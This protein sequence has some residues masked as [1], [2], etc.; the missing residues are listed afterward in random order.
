MVARKA[1]SRYDTIAGSR[2][3]DVVKQALLSIEKPITTFRDFEG[4]ARERLFKDLIA[5][6]VDVRCMSALNAELKQRDLYPVWL[7]DG[8]EIGPRTLTHKIVDRLWKRSLFTH[9]SLCKCN[10]AQLREIVGGRD[11]P[12]LMHYLMDV[13]CIDLQKSIYW[14]TDRGFPRQGAE[15]LWKI[16]I[17]TISDLFAQEYSYLDSE[18][19]QIAAMR[20]GAERDQCRTI[21]YARGWFKEKCPDL[22]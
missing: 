15:Y 14:Y 8:F 3:P 16:D 9:G 7:E 4:R 21:M 18:H 17:R 12:R 13:R 22:I 11:Y 2:L 1:R 10:Q 19:S 6:G 20:T 5:K